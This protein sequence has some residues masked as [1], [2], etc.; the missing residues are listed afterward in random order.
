[1]DLVG[2]LADWPVGS[3]DATVVGVGGVLATTGGTRVYPWASVTKI[4][5]ALTVLDAAADGLVDLEESAGPPGSTVAHLLAH[6]SGI[7]P[8]SDQVLARPASRR[9]YSNRGYEVAAEVVEVRTGEAFADRLQHRVLDP[10]GMTQTS[11]VGSPASGARG[12]I[13]D[14]ATLAI[15]L[16]RPSVLELEVIEQATTTAFPGLPGVLPGFG[17][18]DPNDWALG[19]EVRGT[20][21]PHWT[22]ASNSPATAGH[23]GQS[24]SFLWV[25]RAAGLG[26]VSLSDTAFATWAGIVWPR[27]SE[28]VLEEFRQP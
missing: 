10:L 19:C 23:F 20:K 26:C 5:T 14:L 27:L 17:R 8:E 16:L 7:A 9:I 3:A 11:L 2:E 4:L 24:G 12:P 15:E 21:N 25:D 1:V 6:A 28:R 22:A 18:Q 13:E